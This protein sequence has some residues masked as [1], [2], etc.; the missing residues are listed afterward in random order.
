MTY[1]E[2]FAPFHERV[3]LFDLYSHRTLTWTDD[4]NLDAALEAF[5][6]SWTELLT[7]LPPEERPVTPT[8]SS[9]SLQF[10]GT[11][12]PSATVDRVAKY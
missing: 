10:E 11:P 4:P 3:R 2:S 7:L 1:A 8:T 6:Q 9:G 5:H 12:I